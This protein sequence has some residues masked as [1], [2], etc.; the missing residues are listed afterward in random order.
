MDINTYDLISPPAIHCQKPALDRYREQ[1]ARC[2]PI[3]IKSKNNRY[4]LIGVVSKTDD[5]TSNE[6]YTPTVVTSADCINKCKDILGLKINEIAKLVGISRA[7]LD[8]HK[9]GAPV[10]NMEAYER[11]YAFVSDIEAT[12]GTSV[13]KGIRNILVEKKTLAQHLVSN[14]E[15]LSQCKYIIDEVASKLV[16]VNTFKTKVDESKLDLRLTG[17]GRMA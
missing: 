8:L 4:I 16:N 1:D 10:K 6:V 11:L 14:R 12:Y 2:L 5:L 15:D 9:K 7:T 17:I 3:T 13:S